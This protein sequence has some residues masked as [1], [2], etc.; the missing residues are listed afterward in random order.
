M[1][2]AQGAARPLASAGSDRA[3]QTPFCVVEEESG[4]V[5]KSMVLVGVV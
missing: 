2:E 5:E 3:E 1:P 4:A